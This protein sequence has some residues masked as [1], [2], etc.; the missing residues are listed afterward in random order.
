MNK[1]MGPE[2]IHRVFDEF[3]EGNQQ[4]PRMW[5]VNNESLEENPH[6][7]LLDGFGI[8]LSKEIK[9]GAAKVLSVTVG[10]PQMVDHCIQKQIATCKKHIIFSQLTHHSKANMQIPTFG[11]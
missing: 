11:I 6:D 1:F 3:N 2:L 7:L 5:S 4:T 9:N 8:G 10:I